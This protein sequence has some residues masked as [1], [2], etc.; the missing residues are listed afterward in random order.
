MVG[1]LVICDVTGGVAEDE[2]DVTSVNEA[3]SVLEGSAGCLRVLPAAVGVQP[4]LRYIPRIALYPWRKYMDAR[5]NPMF[6]SSTETLGRKP[7]QNS[8]KEHI[9]VHQKWTC[10]ESILLFCREKKC[11]QQCSPAK[12]VCLLAFFLDISDKNGEKLYATGSATY[13]DNRFS[14]AF[15]VLDFNFLLFSLHPSSFCRCHLR[16]E[17]M[18]HVHQVSLLLL[19]ARPSPFGRVHWWISSVRKMGKWRYT[20]IHLCC[21][22]KKTSRENVSFSC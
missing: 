19:S 14:N 6:L 17:N 1:A 22:N 7:T 10:S 15:C 9:H 20:D 18:S 21:Q 12:L 16:V 13:H 2:N 3:S 4:V 11:H 8:H 5:I